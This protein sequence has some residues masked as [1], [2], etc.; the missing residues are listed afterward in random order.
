MSAQMLNCIQSSVSDEGALKVVTS[1]ES[2]KIK[3]KDR[4]HSLELANWPLYLKS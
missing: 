1:V 4:S 3:I 2:F